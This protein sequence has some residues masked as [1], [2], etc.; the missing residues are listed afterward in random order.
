MNSRSPSRSFSNFIWVFPI[1]IRTLTCSA[2]YHILYLSFS[3]SL[4]LS[5]FVTHTHTHTLSLSLSLSLSS[6]FYAFS[7]CNTYTH[8]LSFSLS[9]SLSYVSSLCPTLSLCSSHLLSHFISLTLCLS[10][11]QRVSHAFIWRILYDVYYM[12]YTIW[13][14]LYDVYYMYTIYMINAPYIIH[15]TNSY[16]L[17]CCINVVHW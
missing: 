12:T 3:L 7:L 17:Y 15:Y 2:G 5:R 11:S 13:R 10:V 1:T 8:T 9:L 14:I 4:T 6:L 16:T